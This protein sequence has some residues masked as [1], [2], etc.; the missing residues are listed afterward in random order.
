MIISFLFSIVTIIT[1][2]FQMIFIHFGL[3]IKYRY[4]SFLSLFYGDVCYHACFG[5]PFNHFVNG[6]GKIKLRLYSAIFGATVN[7]PLSIYF[8]I[9]INLGIS[10]VILATIV[11]DF[12]GL[13]I[14]PIQYIKIINNKAHGIWNS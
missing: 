1:S 14:L 3:G 10:G 12:I 8:A 9:N 11:S 13:T 6:S 4:L 2:I 5:Q 7:I